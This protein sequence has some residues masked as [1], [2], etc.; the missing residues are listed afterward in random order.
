[1][2]GGVVIT[3]EAQL[4]ARNAADGKRIIVRYIGVQAGLNHIPPQALFNVVEGDYAVG[5][6][7]T[8]KTAFRLGLRVEVIE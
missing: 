8:L 5:S 1:V 2:G 7:I 3:S 4:A 6:T